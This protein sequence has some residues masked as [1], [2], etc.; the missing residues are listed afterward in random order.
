MAVAVGMWWQAQV[1]ET[2]AQVLCREPYSILAS[3]CRTK[4]SPLTPNTRPPHQPAPTRSYFLDRDWSVGRFFPQLSS[5]I[6]VTHAESH[7]LS[8]PPGL[9][10]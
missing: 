5:T 9:P 4:D 1:F 6:M 7:C 8:L 3:L 2:T 10:G